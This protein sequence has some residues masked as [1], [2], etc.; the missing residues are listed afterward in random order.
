MN[1]ALMPRQIWGAPVAIGLV[2]LIGLVAA[3]LADGLGDVVSWIALAVPV[4]VCVR[5]LWLP[6]RQEAIGS[7]RTVT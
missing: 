5:A 4:I 7:T 6:T 2:S 3:L 1:N